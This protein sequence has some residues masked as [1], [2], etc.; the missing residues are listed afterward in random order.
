MYFLLNTFQFLIK[1]AYKSDTKQETG[2]GWHNGDFFP[3]NKDAGTPFIAGFGAGVDIGF[4]KK[5]SLFSV[6]MMRLKS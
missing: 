6:T 1:T 3:L 4:G 5:C 2:N